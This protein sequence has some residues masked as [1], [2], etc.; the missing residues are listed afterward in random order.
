[1]C[2]MIFLELIKILHKEFVI[3]SLLIMCEYI[4]I[5]AAHFCAHLYAQL[6]IVTHLL[7]VMNYIIIMHLINES[8]LCI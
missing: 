2:E 5:K 6:W 3:I 7:N 1:M 4:I 8:Q